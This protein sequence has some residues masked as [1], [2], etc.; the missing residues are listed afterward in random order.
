[1]LSSSQ[2]MA[3]E[4]LHAR[5][6]IHRDI[7]PSNFMILADSPSP[8]SFLIDFGL[9]QRFRNPMSYL[10]IQYSKHDPLVGTLPFTSITGHQGGTQSRRDD[11]ESFAYTIICSARGELPWTGHRNPRT[12][13]QK[14][15]ETPVEELCQGLPA[16][17]CGFVTYV[18]SLAFDEKPDYQHL[19]SILSLCLETEADHPIKAPPSV[20]TPMSA[21]RRPVDSDRV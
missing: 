1:M 11:L 10:H 14:K 12:I 17:F 18:R 5:H 2:L 4:S 8:V 21:K 16:P 7:K 6:Y 13:L 20:R 15:L 3:I 19:H 9:A